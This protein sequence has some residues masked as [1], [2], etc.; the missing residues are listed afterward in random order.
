MSEIITPFLLLLLCVAPT[1]EEERLWAV[2]KENAA[3]F[4]AWTL[5]IQ[6]TEKLVRH[7]E[8]FVL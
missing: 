1:S 8:L 5:L 7:D 2:V 4:N 6:E 3:D